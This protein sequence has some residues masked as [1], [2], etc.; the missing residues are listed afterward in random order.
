ML[1]ITQKLNSF[2]NKQTSIHSF[3][4]YFKFNSS[5]SAH[6]ILFHSHSNIWK[7]HLDLGNSLVNVQSAGLKKTPNASLQRS[8]TLID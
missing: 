8:K 7:Y 6:Q 5:K 4:K 1:S 3:P 2:F